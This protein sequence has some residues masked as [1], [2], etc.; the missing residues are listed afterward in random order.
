MRSAD[1]APR[2][3][4]G[5]TD[6]LVC[7]NRNPGAHQAADAGVDPYVF[8][9]LKISATASVIGAIIG[10]LPAGLGDGLGRSLLTFSYYYISGPEKL[11][12]AIIVSAL[13]GITFVSLVAIA[14]RMVL[15][16]HQAPGTR[17]Q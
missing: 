11:Y 13:L 10:E 9:A 7:G 17:R 14:E 1:C 2:L 8:T 4:R 15:S 5:R 6:A 3:R 16:R 12:A